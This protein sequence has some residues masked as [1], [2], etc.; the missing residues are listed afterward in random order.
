MRS[1]TTTVIVESLGA[2]PAS[3]HAV[4]FLMAVALSGTAL[5]QSQPPSPAVEEFAESAGAV[6]FAAGQMI[7]QARVCGGD[8]KVGHAIRK[9]MTERARQCA[10][11]D[12]RVKEVADQMDAAFDAMLKNADT[13]IARRGKDAICT[14]YRS[15]D[16]QV[17]V[18][19][20]LQMGQQLAT[21]AGRDRI[22]QLPCPP[23]D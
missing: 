1:K 2:R 13:T 17:E 23:K 4:A 3:A 16:L 10:A 22:R 21:D 9:L 14:L 18:S 12:L 11:A 7:I 5:A 19:T 6:V 20:A 8:E 15:A